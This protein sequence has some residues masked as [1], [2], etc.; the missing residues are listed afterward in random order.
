LL[1]PT[2]RHSCTE[3][4]PAFSRTEACG[5][6]STLAFSPPDRV[7][8]FLMISGDVGPPPTMTNRPLG[9]V[10]PLQRKAA[11]RRN[12][13]CMVVGGIGFPSALGENLLRSGIK[14]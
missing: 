14:L 8:V 4:S 10:G 13:W 1:A 12:S 7:K 11:V 9:G 6:M 3:D 2:L 5:M